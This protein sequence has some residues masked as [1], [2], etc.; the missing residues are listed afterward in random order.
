MEILFD[1]PHSSECVLVSQC[2]TVICRVW[3]LGPSPKVILTSTTRT[4][5]CT[6][7]ASTSRRSPSHS[8]ATLCRRYDH[9]SSPTQR[10]SIRPNRFDRAIDSMNDSKARNC[11]HYFGWWRMMMMMMQWVAMVVMCL[12]YIYCYLRRFAWRASWMACTSSCPSRHSHSASGT[13]WCLMRF[14]CCSL[15]TVDRSI[16]RKCRWS[17]SGKW[18]KASRDL[19]RC[20]WMNSWSDSCQPRMTSWW[21]ESDTC[22]YYSVSRRWLAFWICF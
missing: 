20:W 9:R 17:C 1:I 22:C 5:S 11:V 15:R 3:A 18:W 16:D 8:W 4:S 21:M 6:G 7:L 19:W 14:R 12:S 10:H 2:S 13:S